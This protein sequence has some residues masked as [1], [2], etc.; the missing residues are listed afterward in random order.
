MT[1]SGLKFSFQR[2]KLPYFCA[3]HHNLYMQRCIQLAQ[4]GLGSTGLNPLV[5]AVI[6]HDGHII[7]EGYHSR[8][9]GPHAEVEA[10]RSV[11]D[12][13]AL[14]HST[15]YV[16]LEPCSHYGKTPPCAQ[17][18]LDHGIGHVVYGM[19]DPNPL[20]AGRGIA[21]LRSA[22]VEVTGPILETENRLLNKRFVCHITK[23]RPWILLKWAQSNDGFMD[24]DRSQGQIGSVA[25]SG[26]LAQS[27]VHQWR[28]Q[29][30]SILIGVQ[31]AIHDEPKLSLRFAAGTQPMRF[32][33]DPHNRLPAHH[34]MYQDGLP[35]T[36]ICQ[37]PSEDGTPQ[38]MRIPAPFQ[39]NCI[40][41][42]IYEAGI[43]SVLVEGGQRTLQAFIDANLWDEARVFESPNA[44]EQG[45][46]AP[47]LQMASS[48]SEKV[49]KDLLHLYHNPNE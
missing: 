47:R 1:D 13:E 23:Q 4:K 18:I 40:M 25:I 36:V 10:I 8:Y 43:A 41:Q 21:L 29:E 17:L 39:L 49:G 48:H 24:V 5:G 33:V 26:E 11:V 30:M 45:L 3:M 31:T 2:A 9:G 7:G 34:P 37:G 19:Q 38:I 6:V 35:L 44:L 12:R 16:N 20:V 28:G 22:G 15:L 27:W 46:K 32:V 42:K 14:R